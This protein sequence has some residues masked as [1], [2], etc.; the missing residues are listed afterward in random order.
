MNKRNLKNTEWAI[1]ICVLLLVIIGLIALYSAS[2][3]T[4]LDAFKKQCIWIR[5]R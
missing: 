3:E 2:P 5:Y 1:L 4:E